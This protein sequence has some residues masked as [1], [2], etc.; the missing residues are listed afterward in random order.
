MQTTAS[1][2]ILLVALAAVANVRAEYKKFEYTVLSSPAVDI[3]KIDVTPMPIF[4]PGE[5]FLS[6]AA[7]LKRPIR[8]CHPS[9]ILASLTSFLLETIRT[10]LK[11]VRT[12]SNIALPV[13]C[14]KVEG[15]EVGSC[16]YK[17]LCLVLKSLLP[18][19]KP[20]TC[21]PPMAQYGIDC[22]CPFNIR[23]GQITIE[24]EKLVLPDA[25]ATIAN[26]MA[27]GD[28]SIQLDTY[29]TSGPYAS[30][31]IKFTVK[32]AKPSG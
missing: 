5:A 23:T 17:D 18:T 26:F 29:D 21:P 9:S 28:F 22:T 16:D 2:A 19:F 4:N 3:Q 8:K 20:D 11:I 25:Q 13:R 24:N 6:F 12:V 10:V 14:Y 30:L 32:A 15:V 1:I 31:I 27:T 7:N